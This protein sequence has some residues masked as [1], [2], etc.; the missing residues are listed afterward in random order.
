MKRRQERT[1]LTEAHKKKIYLFAIIVALIFIAAVGYLVG[2]PMI[3]FV[4]EPERFRAWV[5]SS[6]FVSRV[7]FV[8]MVIFQLIIA[9]IPGEPLEM[10]AGY[11][12]GAW[13][14]TILCIIGCVIGSALVFLFVRR[15]GVKLVEVFFPREKIRS[16]R[17]LQDSRRLD[18]LTF[19][20]FF[21]PGTPKDLLSYFIGLTD[22]KL[23]TWLL[24]TAVA[25]IP[26]IVTS[27]VT[28]DA[29]GL[30]DYQFALIA[31]GVTLALSL[32]GILVY[33]RLSARR[34]PN[35]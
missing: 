6:G 2:K 34:H 3:E 22:M 12:F 26:S 4:R 32:A 27:T 14:G 24:I 29:L 15:F 5:D 7:I 17:F 9:L 19:I 10:G 35:G 11:A 33:R 16:L 23:G 1:Q 31:F 8:G 18:L 21:I 13:E 28:G 25:R 20:V 30:K